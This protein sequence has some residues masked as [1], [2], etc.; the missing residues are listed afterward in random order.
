VLQR[1]K[2][3]S[4]KSATL[5]NIVGLLI[6]KNRQAILTLPAFMKAG[7]AHSS[8]E[9]V[10]APLVSFNSHLKNRMFRPTDLKTT[11]IFVEL[12]YIFFPAAC[13][14]SVTSNPGRVGSAETTEAKVY[15]GSQDSGYQKSEGIS[16]PCNSARR[17]RAQFN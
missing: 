9:T 5:K 12:E 13:Q 2:E 16:H 1:E 6:A 10:E 17:A 14:D 4:G 11:S 15:E 8:K 7:A 3:L